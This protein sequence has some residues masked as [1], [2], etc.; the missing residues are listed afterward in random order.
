MSLRGT[1]SLLS[2]RPVSVSKNMI[3]I[4]HIRGSVVGNIKQEEEIVKIRK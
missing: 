1:N 3:K 2:K 4:I